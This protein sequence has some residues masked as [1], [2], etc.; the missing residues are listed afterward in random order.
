M[1]WNMD[2]DRP[3]YIQ[4]VERIRMQI[5]SG[6]Y[7]PGDKLPTVREL[8]AEAAVNPNTMQKAF[9]ELERN[10]L[11]I[12]WR[13][14]G[15]TVTQDEELIERIRSEMAQMHVQTFMKSMKELGFDGEQIRQFF[16]QHMEDGDF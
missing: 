3:I 14:N 4:L 12:T 9:A 7:S 13:T 8:S 15:R 5:V 1:A 11:I 10:G 6:Y 16:E 2:S